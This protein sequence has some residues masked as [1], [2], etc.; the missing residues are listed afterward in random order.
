MIPHTTRR[1]DRR[2]LREIGRL[3]ADHR[4]VVIGGSAGGV[5]ALTRLVRA[6]RAGP[7]MSCSLIWKCRDQWIRGRTGARINRPDLPV[8]MSFAHPDWSEDAG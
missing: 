3:P 1:R 7:L 4:V 8:I 6:F 5:E 2:R